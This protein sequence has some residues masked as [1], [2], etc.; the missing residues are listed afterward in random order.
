[1]TK[2]GRA[3]KKSGEQPAATVKGQL[4]HTPP[5]RFNVAEVFLDRNVREGKSAKVA[6][7]CGEE[8]VT[9]GELVGNANRVGNVLRGLGVRPEERVLLLLPD[10]PE[11]LYAFFGVIKIGAVAV[12]LNT[13]LKPHEYAYLFH[14]ARARVLIASETLLAPLRSLPRDGLRYLRDILVVGES[15]PSERSLH[16]SMEEVPAELQPERMSRDDVAFWLYSSGSTGAPKACIHL[17]HDMM[18]CSECYARGI[19]RMNEDDRCYSV[20][21][22]FFAYG[23][24]NIGYFPLY[25]G[26]TTILS[27]ARHTPASVYADI[28]RYRPTLFFSVPTNYAALLDWKPEGRHEFDLSSVRHAISA[29]E[30]LP[31]AIFARFKERFGIEILDAWG[32]TETLQMAISNRPGEA[33]AGSS[34]KVIPGY[35]A[36]IVDEGG[37][38]VARGQIGNLLIKGDSTCAGY[39]NH[40]ERTKETFAG[41]WFRTGDTYSQDEDGYFWYAGRKDDLFKVNG[42]WLSPAEVESA[43]TAHPSV[44]EAAVVARRDKNGIVKPA[45]YVVVRANSPS[46]GAL[47]EELQQWV[48]DQIG[49]YKRPRWIEFVQELPKTATGKLQRYKLREQNK[50]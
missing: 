14:D 30:A 11:F 29:G 10:I 43:L 25:C 23:L 26:A 12:P 33:R 39:W 3:R 35:E 41:H 42:R 37:A 21:R 40:H 13:L 36:K 50:P 45:A 16:R 28:E 9:Y 8:K 47:S 4:A 19:L 17:H 15:G 24:G 44:R 20:A 6:I 1:M 32:S 49:A 31:A 27:P 48:A 5:A 46:G 22:L 2:P 38:P 34:G 18:V 7:E